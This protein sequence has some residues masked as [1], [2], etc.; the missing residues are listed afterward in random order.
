MSGDCLF[1][2]NK[3]ARIDVLG[4]VM[5]QEC[6]QLGIDIGSTTAKIV[7]LDSKANLRFSTYRR[8]NAETVQ[9][10][11][12]ALN[13][14]KKELGNLPVQ[15]Q[16]TGSAGMGVSEMYEI[17]FIQ[18]VVSS[19]EVVR[20]LYPEVKTLIDIGGEDAKMIFFHEEGVP[21]I[22]MNGS[23]AGGTGAFIDQMATLLNIEVSAL[24]D[25]ALDAKKIY[26]IAS[27]CGVFAKT[28]VQNLLSRQVSHA[29][30]AASI[31]HAVALQVTA[32]LSRGNEP[33]PKLLMC[34]GPLTFIP[35]LRSAFEEVLN[36]DADDILAVE[37][38]ELLPAMGAALSARDKALPTTL[39]DLIL[40]LEGKPLHVFNSENR[41]DPLFK[42]KEDFDL[43]EFTRNQNKVPRAELSEL[44][45]SEVFLGVDSGSTTTKITL[46]DVEGRLL[47]SHYTSNNGD[48]IG[49]VKEGLKEIRALF[50]GL[51]EPPQITRT[52]VT[53]YGEDLIKAVFGF[54]LGM[55]ET[56]AHF[57]AARAFDPQVSFILDIG[58][59]DMKA[60]YVQD[61][62]IQNIELN[63]ACS[64]GC[65]SFIETF[66]DSM[67]YT[68]ADFAYKATTAKAPS[69]LGTRCTVFM[70][71]KVKQ[72]LREGASVN[73]ISA[74]L[75][76]SV[77]KNALHKVLKITNTDVLGDHILVQGGTFRNPAI[78]KA[79]E[80]LLEKP[81]L[82]PDVSELMGAYGAALVGR[83][84]YLDS[85]TTETT[86]IG[87]DALD[88]AA[89]YVKRV[90]TCR[91]C[92]NRCSVTKLT[93]P[94]KRVFYTG[95]RC[96]R[97]Y[98]NSGKKVKKGDDMTDFKNHLLFDREKVPSGAP[99]QVIG[100]PRTLNMF[101]NY[102][103]WNTLFVES[104]FEVKLSAPSSNEVY[105][106][107]AGT[108]MSE[109]ICYPAKLAHGHV[110]D[111]IEAGVDRIFYPMVTF[112]EKEFSDALNS[113]NC[114]IVSGYPDVIRSAINP[115]KN[116][117][118]P[119]DTP[120]VTF[121]DHNALKKIVTKYLLS[122]GVDK[123]TARRAYKRALAEQEAYKNA[124]R[125]EGDRIL[126]R[127]ETE[128]RLVVL[129]LGRPYHAD[130]LINHD[131]PSILTDFGVD[132]ITED[133]LGLDYNAKLNNP[134]VLTQ[135][136]YPNRYYYAMRWAGKHENVE[137]VQLNSFGCGP[138]AIAVDEVHSIASEYDMGHTVI[139]IDEIE[140]TG[141]VRLRLRS[142]IESV[143]QKHDKKKRS[144]TPRKSIKVYQKEDRDK[145]ILAPQFSYF[146]TAPLVRP[147]LDMGYKMEMLPPP[148]R[149][150]AEV[151]LKYTNNEICYP[152]IV[153]IGDLIK[154]LQSGK[155]D[156]DKVAV[157]ITQTGGQCRASSY[158]SLLRRALT[159]AGFYNTP[160][161]S[162]T[163][164]L[165]ALN[166]QPG[167]KF[168][169]KSYAYRSVL[170]I[171][172]TDAL[173]EL[174]YATAIREV[175]KG[176]AL[177]LA[178]KYMALLAN[179]I[180]KGGMRLERKN[181]MKILAQ[182]IDEFNRI[183]VREGSFPKVGIIGE[184]YAKYN[185]F[186]NNRV[187]QW[188]MDQGLEVVSPP[189]MEFFAAW[190]VNSDTNVHLNLKKPDALWFLA[191][192]SERYT[193]S[194]LE[195]VDALMQAFPYHRP[196]HN[197]H[198]IAEKAE[199]I[200]HLTHQYGEGWLIPGEISSFME[201]G[202]PN[203]LCLQPFGCIANH[204]VAKGV[205]KR[206]KEDHPELNLLFLDVDAGV[207]EVNFVNRLHFFVSHAKNQA[208][209]PE[210]IAAIE[211][212]NLAHTTEE[213]AIC[214][215]ET[216]ACAACSL[217]LDGETCILKDTRLAPADEFI[218]TE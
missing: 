166:E 45:S 152:A 72:S 180:E 129:L 194:L 217:N 71:S 107:G 169:I 21:D 187:A 216:S 28:D 79:M 91:G 19:A 104:G 50:Q 165:K 190:Y 162:L 49:A 183:P 111:L 163:T 43:W 63:E 171:A 53:G 46:I 161:I 70:N 100:I 60:I 199:E 62:H 11:L 9:T 41:L 36:L 132:V 103:F 125:A 153:V 77:I 116:F 6:Y 173:S 68:V 160:I 181:V 75:A 82:C 98:S 58:G 54:D 101:E 209:D 27:R 59:Q 14:A 184:I 15:V 78:H 128:D 155:Y 182:V 212:E 175:N 197:I 146:Y 33:K 167:F 52:V 133:A 16:I 8:H 145:V 67:G 83:D 96:E 22:R 5:L 210:I 1:C 13:E 40:R 148:N 55:V 211:A 138:D 64:S 202:V 85:P 73:D 7:L 20:R 185:A 127:A 95:N 214:V 170:G 105:A 208:P 143:Q 130:P 174:Y 164:G 186:S 178:D 94:N 206:M 37:H 69:D 139:R 74:G 159:A 122:L 65:G 124:V 48:A 204:V 89:E 193:L 140:S 81:V 110:Y 154:A 213:G 34:G 195:E 38:S 192:V 196:M 144:Y 84:E 108:I 156:P 157:G 189:L 99:R 61:G 42:N 17:P 198:H 87:L 35:S 150:T 126:A 57:R 207:S 218:L 92:E 135:W 18:E 2:V 32:T 215:M 118:I 119:F 25:L 3:V 112:E 131:V 51:E 31:F 10:L 158:L 179:P 29:D 176:D 117:N 66:A 90:I 86:F 188:L 201:D 4:V 136:E 44:E 76:Y 120:A 114:P 88:N 39:F 113:F 106:R 168:D 177:K 121:R 26:P 151:G 134:H 24:G 147:I 80:T 205:E 123:K 23:C 12:D 191:K 30:I 141:S 97:I 149:E 102:P 203:V 56:L 200:V 172:F 109:N 47:Y 137:V 142:M 93:F 115:E